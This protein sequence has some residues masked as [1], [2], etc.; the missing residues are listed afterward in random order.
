M[1]GDWLGS[2]EPQEPH[3]GVAAPPHVC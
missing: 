2:R 1:P 3:W